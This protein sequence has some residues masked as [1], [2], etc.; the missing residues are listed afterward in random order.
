MLSKY[1]AFSA[2]IYLVVLMNLIFLY[3]FQVQPRLWNNV[4]NMQYFNV[5]L[6]VILKLFFLQDFPSQV[7]HI[8]VSCVDQFIMCRKVQK[9]ELQLLGI[10]C[11]LIAARFQG[12]DIITIR[13]AAWLTDNTYKYED[14][15]R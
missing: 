12:K 7:V 13:E 10:T 4:Y 6:S 1:C 15:V 9:S 14:V 5:T 11:I 3:T 8:A 2:Y